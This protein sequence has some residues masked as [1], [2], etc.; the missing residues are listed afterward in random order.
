MRKMIESAF[1]RFG[2]HCEVT[3]GEETHAVRAFI[4]PITKETWDE[5]FSVGVL[6]AREECIWRYLGAAAV[7]VREGDSVLITAEELYHGKVI[8]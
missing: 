4:Q 3:R 5:P 1:A 7:E 8:S 6:G 2:A